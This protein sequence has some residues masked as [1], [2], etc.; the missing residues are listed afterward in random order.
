[1]LEL[2]LRTI[3]FSGIYLV[4]LIVAFMWVLLGGAKGGLATIIMVIY[5]CQMFVPIGA[6]VIVNVSK[7]KEMKREFNKEYKARLV[8][9][10]GALGAASVVQLILSGILYA[11]SDSD[12]KNF[13]EIYL[14]PMYLAIFGIVQSVIFT[15]LLTF[16]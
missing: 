12:V 9:A 8:A 13:K 15:T 7:L 6:L 16:T 14:A 5:G 4:Y 1:M 3:I 10:Y 11:I 2:R